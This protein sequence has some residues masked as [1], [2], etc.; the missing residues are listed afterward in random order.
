MS[1]KNFNLDD[2]FIAILMIGMLGLF[3]SAAYEAKH[4]GMTDPVVVVNAAAHNAVAKSNTAPIT[5]NRKFE[6]TFPSKCPQ[7]GV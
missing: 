1:M 4:N 3:G 2:S 6:R 5:E 7:Q